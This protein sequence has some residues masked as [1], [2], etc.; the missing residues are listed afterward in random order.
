[1]PAARAPLVR[2]C[3]ARGRM[4]SMQVSGELWPFC[5][6]FRSQQQC[7]FLLSCASPLNP[8]S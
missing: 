3:W 7:A 2:L 1:M 5:A 8:Y 6:K 4:C